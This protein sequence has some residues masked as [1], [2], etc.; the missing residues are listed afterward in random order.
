[1]LL[2]GR[3]SSCSSAFQMP[4]PLS[5]HSATRCSRM[6]SS[7]GEKGP[8]FMSWI[9]TLRCMVVHLLRQSFWDRFSSCGQC[10]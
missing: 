1:M 6:A 9:T 4:W 7:S 3:P 2:E 10:G 5:P 8:F